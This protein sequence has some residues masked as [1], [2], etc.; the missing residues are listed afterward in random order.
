[1]S[2][3]NQLFGQNPLAGD[4]VKAIGVGGGTSYPVP[5]FRDCHLE[6]VDGELRAVLFTR[7]GGGNRECWREEE[8]GDHG[9]ENCSGCS[10]ELLVTHPLYVRDYDDDF[11]CT[12]ASFEFKLPEKAQPFFR[13]LRDALGQKDA[14]AP[15]ERFKGLIDK[16]QAGI[17]EKEDPQVARAMSVGRSIFG[18]LEEAFASNDPKDKIIEV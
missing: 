4:L 17:G 18:R 1:M 13:A 15:M 10:N 12:Y 11:D 9:P 3:Y 6:E 5:R 16:L 7:Q 14:E 2:L 8:E